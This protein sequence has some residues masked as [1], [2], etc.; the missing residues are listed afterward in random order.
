M[1]AALAVVVATAAGPASAVPGGKKPRFETEVTVE[2]DFNRGEY[3]G[4]V[5]SEVRQCQKARFVVIKVRDGRIPSKGGVIPGGG[6]IQGSTVGVDRTNE[7]GDYIVRTGASPP[8]TGTYRA[9]AL[10]DI[11]NKYICEADLSPVMRVDIPTQ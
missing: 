6:G 2:Y 5:T 11:R 10:K 7:F 1:V 4:S 9:R 8:F 3:V